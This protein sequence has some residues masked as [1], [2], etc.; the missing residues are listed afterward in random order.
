MDTLDLRQTTTM[1]PT[2]QGRIQT[3]IFLSL[4][5][6]LPITTIFAW[7]LDSYLPFIYLTITFL[8]GINFELISHE[9]QHFSWDKDWPPLFVILFSLLEYL[10]V[11]L[12][13]FTAALIL[14]GSAFAA[15]PISII[16]WHYF[17]IWCLSYLMLVQGLNIL[18][19]RRRF[20]GGKIKIREEDF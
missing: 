7:Y 2:R 13:R 18:F 20:T 14:P 3:K 6:G 1:I 19:P 5:I 10:M 17:S 15:V 4:V 8:I 11:I 9:F 12:I 16:S